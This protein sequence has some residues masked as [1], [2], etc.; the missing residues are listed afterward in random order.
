MHR[1][2]HAKKLSVNS[3]VY[4]TAGILLLLAVLSVWM[5]GGLSAKYVVSERSSDS[6]KVADFGVGIKVIEHDAKLIEDAT[7]AVEKDSVY[8]L[9]DETVNKNLY[10][11][12]M[13]GVDI[14]KDP[15]IVITG[16]G[17]VSCE[18]YVKVTEKDL[19]DTVT[20]KM[21]DGWELEKTETLQSGTTVHTFKYNRVLVPP[22]SGEYPI[23]KDNKLIV[24]DRY[25]GNG[26]DFSLTFNAWLVQ[27]EAD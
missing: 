23:L 20:Y 13:P 21:A 26:R 18:L 25:V 16:N 10:K 2:K 7:K 4:R 15:F 12:V 17:E 1:G 8:E 9:T 14:P 6:A 5:L 3:V 19:P 24:S 11:A 27:A 22:F